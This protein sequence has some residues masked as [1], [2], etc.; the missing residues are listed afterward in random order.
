MN[1]AADAERR[2]NDHPALD[3]SSFY[4]IF[5]PPS[6]CLGALILDGENKISFLARRRAVGQ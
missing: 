5:H 2:M 3:P 4:T 6:I 1:W